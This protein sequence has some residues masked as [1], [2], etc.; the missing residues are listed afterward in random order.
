MRFLDVFNEEYNLAEA[1]QLE[2]LFKLGTFEPMSN[3]EHIRWMD[4]TGQKATPVMWKY[5]VKPDRDDTGLIN[6]F[7]A[8]LVCLGNLQK[9]YFEPH[10]IYSPVVQS[11]SSRVFLAYA[12]AKGMK[13]RQYDVPTAFLRAAPSRDT[14]ISSIPGYKQTDEEGKPIYYKLKRNLYGS[15]ESAKCFQDLCDKWLSE[16]GFKQSTYEPCLYINR[17]KG[18]II[19]LY[20]DDLAVASVDDAAHSWIDKEL[21]EK[22][23]IKK[24]GILNNYLGCR[25]RQKK[26]GNWF[27]DQE[28]RIS[29]IAS[30]YNM[31]KGKEQAPTPYLN[32]KSN[33]F[34]WDLLTKDEEELERLF[35]E[36]DCHLPSLV[37][38]LLYIAKSSRPD[39]LTATCRIA[40][41]VAYAS[42]EVI[43]AAKRIVRY[44]YLTRKKGITLGSAQQGLVTAWVDSSYLG[45]NSD[46]HGHSRYGY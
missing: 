11:K 15:V 9:K 30:R 43:R 20:V 29:R 45:E 24:Q 37:G 8:R 26:D 17:E 3:K 25:Y 12:L 4:T 6:E 46:Y 34:D 14:V 7:R 2:K 10:E 41:H 1:V 36:H 27:I 32:A 19:S 35:K 39:I 44:L 28:E 13:V 5:D 16:K 38:E 33:G 42:E 22:F 23:N 18:V 21:E 40:S 31:D